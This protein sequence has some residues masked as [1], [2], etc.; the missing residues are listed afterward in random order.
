MIDRFVST[1]KGNKIKRTWMLLIVLLVAC[2]PSPQA[3]QTAI[4]ETESAR[5]PVPTNTFIPTSTTPIPAALIPA[6]DV[7]AAFK[8][9]GLQA[10]GARPLTIAD[11]ALVPYVCQGLRF[12]IPSLGPDNGGRIFICDN[13]GDEDT[14]SSYYQSFGQPGSEFFSWV[15][16]K[17]NI[18][19]QINGALPE[20]TANQYEAAIP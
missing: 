14:L 13:K 12:F 4:A 6:E 3:I 5:T 20:A 18:V 16:V 2:A 15:F 11:Y 1:R 10:E 7:I 17:G 9:A 19:V 8:A